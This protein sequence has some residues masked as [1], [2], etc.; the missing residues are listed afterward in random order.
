[1]PGAR[2]LIIALI[3]A[4]V[5]PVTAFG[6]G[7]SCLDQATLRSTATGRSAIITFVNN[8]RHATNIYWIDYAGKRAQTFYVTP[9]S[10]ISRNTLVT[11]PWVIT[12]EHDN[13]I[14]V[15][16]ANPSAPNVEITDSAIVYS[17]TSGPAR[18]DNPAYAKQAKHDYDEAGGPQATQAMHHD[19]AGTVTY[20]GQLKGWAKFSLKI[21]PVHEGKSWVAVY[22]GTNGCLGDMAGQATVRGDV[23]DLTKD[24]G[25]NDCGLTVHRSA[26]GATITESNCTF[27]HGASCTFDTQ[28][29]ALHQVSVAGAQ[30][31]AAPVVQDRA[32]QGEWTSI[33]GG[34]NAYGLAD[35]G[36]SNIEFLCNTG[37]RSLIFDFDPRGYRGHALR[38]V[39]DLEQPFILEVRP[40]SGENQKF[41]IMAFFFDDGA[42]VTTR[43]GETRDLG[44]T[45]SAATAFL[46]AFAQEGR[47]NLQTGNGVELVSWTL[48]DTS[49]VRESMRNACQL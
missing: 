10:V 35:D 9:G 39:L 4:L 38:K 26:T 1:M 5:T 2:N 23:L 46:D 22:V 3:F 30:V 12:D 6:R 49:K 16:F 45:G 47:L 40:V 14:G 33:S 7:I 37:K 32:K 8:S 19:E 25:G 11:H 29:K 15:A 28:G 21:G 42:W 48:R 24:D 31:A 20:R 17:G 13:C 41:P 44:L 27:D 18:A 34:L 43:Y 36:I